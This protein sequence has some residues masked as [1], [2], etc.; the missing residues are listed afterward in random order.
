MLSPAFSTGVGLVIDGL[1]STERIRTAENKLKT[2]EAAVPDVVEDENKILG[3]TILDRIRGIFQA[4][5]E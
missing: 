4:E 5:E 2:E 3:R 1:T